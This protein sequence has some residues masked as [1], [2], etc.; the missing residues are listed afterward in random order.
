ML[1]TRRDVETY[2][3]DRLFLVILDGL[4]GEKQEGDDELAL[5]SLDSLS[6]GWAR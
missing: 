4:D 2:P 6:L 1:S 3:P 5:D